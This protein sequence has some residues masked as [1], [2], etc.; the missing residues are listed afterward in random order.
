MN[1]PLKV[2]WVLKVDDSGKT[3][4]DR[5]RPKKKVSTLFSLRLYQEIFKK[6]Y[7]NLVIE[8][9]KELEL[10]KSYANNINKVQPNLHALNRIFLS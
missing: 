5:D 7:K 9:P 4:V 1:I 8:T 10:T 2:E 3:G 6:R